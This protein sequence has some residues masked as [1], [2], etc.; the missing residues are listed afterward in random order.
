MSPMPALPV[1]R[2]SFGIGPVNP[3]PDRHS[4]VSPVVSK[5]VSAVPVAAER[6]TLAESGIG[7][8]TPVEATK[9]ASD[10]LRGALAAEL[11]DAT[12]P[13]TNDSTHLIKF[14]GLYQQDDRDRRKAL[15]SKR[16][17]LAYSCMVRVAV[18]G[19]VLSPLQWAA[20]DRVSDE[21]A[22]GAL[23][24]T[25][26][27]GVQ[28][29]TV[30]KTS[31]RRL[32]QSVHTELLTTL[33][34][35]GDVVRNVCACPAPLTGR[36][37]ALLTDAATV[38]ANHFRP[39]TSAYVEIWLEGEQAVSFES[40]AAS[41]A[42]IKQGEQAVSF[43]AAEIPDPVSP[44]GGDDTGLEPI[45]GD[46]YLPRKFKI[47]VAYPGDNC[48]DVLSQ[49]VGLVPVVANGVSG[50]AV[51]VG[52]GQGQSHARPDDTFPR[53]ATPLGWTPTADVARTIE[54]VVTVFRDHG[55]RGD[56]GR[57]RLKY[58]L[59][60]RGEAWFRAQVEE[61][62]GAPL[63]DIPALPAWDLIH[64]H[65][66]WHE[67]A[68]GTWFL[69]VRVPSGR[70]RDSE[71]VKMRTALREVIAQH[72]GE[73]RIT[74][75]QDVLLCGVA[76]NDRAAV[77]DI[78]RAYGVRLT[79]DLGPVERLAIACPALPTCGQALGEAERILP[80]IVDELEALLSAQSIT[81][82]VRMHMTGCPNGCARPYT[83][84][85][86]IVGRTK[87][88]SDIYLGG[89]PGGDRLAVKLATD[90]DLRDLSITLA[91]IIAEYS[92]ATSGGVDEALGDWAA[93]VGIEKLAE[94]LPVPR[95]RR[96]SA[97]AAATDNE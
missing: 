22:D 28:F 12:A 23:R 25:T 68:D 88:T 35:C 45:Y 33:A 48:V 59:A 67:S 89:S 7:I 61:R 94:L 42:M 47:S 31:L 87:K 14:H 54:A 90:I 78:L 72:V 8:G 29:H 27:Q 51:F 1:V 56:R 85:L 63:A 17:Q 39:R 18:P 4:R 86:G 71:P 80:A 73:V 32:V 57:A 49:D 21:V 69:G 24:L 97:I 6:T 20:L 55:N 79:V 41:P 46:S 26:R 84:E 77:D 2:L 36:D 52:G 11:R 5:A 92:S 65:L 9:G 62:L 53:L 16:E 70:V 91:P 40:G 83:A 10:H 60:D 58:L 38:L 93:R 82:N 50:Y 44:L 66:G 81:R 43:G 96:R 64:D 13:F 76:Y 30:P 34:A 15:A 95:V 19:G 75:N 37:P 3:I 74:A